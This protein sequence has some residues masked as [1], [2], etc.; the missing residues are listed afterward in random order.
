MPYVAGLKNHED[1]IEYL[2]RL[3]K[4]TYLRDIIERNN[5]KNEEELAI[6]ID[7]LASSIG[8]LTNPQKLENTFKTVKK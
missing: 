3:F 5:V 7:I 6:L 4:E 1:K 8:S 2:L